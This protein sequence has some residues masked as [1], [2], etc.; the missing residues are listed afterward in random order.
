MME[1]AF[2]VLSTFGNADEART[3]CRQIVEERLAAC[4]NLLPG[5]ESIYHWEGAMQT[6]TEIMVI[7]KTTASKL[8]MLEARLQELHSYQVPEVIA[9][10][11]HG[12][13]E[14]YLRWIGENVEK[15]D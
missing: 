3:V 8:G 4:A 14:A 11:L 13:A 2:M 6:S 5:V 1:E 15:S 7:F 12:G 10:R 9:L